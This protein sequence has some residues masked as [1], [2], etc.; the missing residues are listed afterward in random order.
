MERRALAQPRRKAKKNLHRTLKK[1]GLTGKIEPSSTEQEY[2]D[3]LLCKLHARYDANDA[4]QAILIERAVTAELRLIRARTLITSTL[5]DIADPENPRRVAKQQ[6]VALTIRTTRDYMQEMFGGAA[7]SL[8]L[9][10]MVAEEAGWI[11]AMPRANRATLTKLMRYAQRF[12]G[13]RDRALIRLNA[14]S[15]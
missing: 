4:Q 12:R 3:E 15:D 14:M 6:Q 7:P 8:S 11:N 1:H 2:L 9:V 10:K 13:E 5:E